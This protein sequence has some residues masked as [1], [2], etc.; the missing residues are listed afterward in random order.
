ML[1]LRSR[2]SRNL[3]M[4]NCAY[5]ASRTPSATFSKSQKTAMFLVSVGVVIS[6]SDVGVTLLLVGDQRNPAVGN[7]LHFLHHV[8]GL[9][10]ARGERHV[11]LLQRLDAVGLAQIPELRGDGEG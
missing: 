2:R 8:G 5:F 11:A 3:P 10:L 9:E 7:Q 6:R 1:P 4:S